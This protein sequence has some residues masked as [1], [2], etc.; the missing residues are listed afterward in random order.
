MQAFPAGQNVC[1][2]FDKPGETVCCSAD[3]LSAIHT[4]FT[5]ANQQL[6]EV[7]AALRVLLLL[8]LHRL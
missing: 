5:A 2:F 3:T 1:R 4:S 6:D 7:R 8:L